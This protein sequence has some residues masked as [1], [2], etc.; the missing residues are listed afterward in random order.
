[1]P[2]ALQG[3]EG[4]CPGCGQNI[5]APLC[6][7]P[8]LPQR[9][10][11]PPLDRTHDSPQE[12]TEAV[13]LPA[14]TGPVPLQARHRQAGL[15][16][17]S[18]ARTVLMP[19]EAE[20]EGAPALPPRWGPAAMS[21]PVRPLPT[22][23]MTV[24]GENPLGKPKPLASTTPATVQQAGFAGPSSRHRNR[25]FRVVLL[26]MLGGMAAGV[27]LYMKNRE[28]G[29][30]LPWKA[31]PARG[32]EEVPGAVWF[33]REAT[34]PAE[35]E[36]QEAAVSGYQNNPEPSGTVPPTVITMEPEPGNQ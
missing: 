23:P 28:W 27:A 8:V 16:P 13:A 30:D 26:I 33:T 2:V 7:V 19:G 14:E 17:P 6:P 24:P 21:V 34:G 31:E 29:K 11:L 36:V 22:P 32:P 3:I 5:S 20:D 12:S 35:A 9:V 15:L 10:Y 1:M 25:I 4:P 18:S